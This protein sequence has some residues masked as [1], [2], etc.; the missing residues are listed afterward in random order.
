LL[1]KILVIGIIFIFLGVCISSNILIKSVKADPGDVVHS[2][3]SPGI[4]PRGL[5]WDGQYIWNVDSYDKK[6]YKLNPMNGSIE[7]DI[8]SPTSAPGGLAWEGA[9][10]WLVDNIGSKKVFKMI[11][12]FNGSVIEGFESPTPTAFGLTWEDTYIWYTD[13]MMAKIFKID[14]YTGNIEHTIPSPENEPYGITWDGVSLWVVGYDARK[15]YKV[16]PS[17]GNILDSFDSPGISPRGLAW[18]GQFLWLSESYND[19]IYQIEIDVNVPPDKPDIDGPSKAPI[20]KELYW[21]FHSTDSNNDNI[22]YIIE[23]GD[24]CSEETG[25]NSACTPVKVYHIYD[26]EGEYKI[27]ATAE[28]IKGNVSE[29]STFIVS[30]QRSKSTSIPLFLWFLERFPM[31]DRLLNLIRLI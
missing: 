12:P 2:F 15:I 11:D 26:K 22:K 31:L 8:D 18:D 27:T 10:L 16:D 19:K 13:Y 1:K 5:A 4:S 14:L 7:H 25:Y 28:D 23:W 6:I 24:G 17:D 9:F 21:I 30:I 3:D 20:G 29:E